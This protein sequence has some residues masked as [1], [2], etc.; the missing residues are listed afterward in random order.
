[1]FFFTYLNPTNEKLNQFEDNIFINNNI[2]GDLSKNSLTAEKFDLSKSYKNIKKEKNKSSPKTYKRAKSLE[3]NDII[4]N[5]SVC[6]L[7][8]KG[9]F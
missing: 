7:T 6:D 9:I 2:H 1:M 5:E 4:E 8:D 3:L